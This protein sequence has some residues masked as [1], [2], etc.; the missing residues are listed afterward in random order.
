MMHD[1]EP[2]PHDVEVVLRNLENAQMEV[3]LIE[4]LIAKLRK[5]GKLAE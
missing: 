1:P 3:G 4:E 5:E 2:K